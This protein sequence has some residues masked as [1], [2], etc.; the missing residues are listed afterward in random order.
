MSA[1]RRV[2]ISPKIWAGWPRLISSIT[3]TYA[4]LGSDFCVIDHFDKRTIDQ[5]QPAVTVRGRPQPS[6]EIFIGEIGVELQ[7]PD[8]A[9]I[10]LVYQTRTPSVLP[11]RSCRYLAGPEESGF[12][13]S[14]IA[15]DYRFD[16]ISFEKTTIL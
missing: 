7:A 1:S 12:S 16:G 14:A 5:L 6:D 3:K 4:A 11:T 15:Q 2:S 9:P 10:A 13:W 8:L